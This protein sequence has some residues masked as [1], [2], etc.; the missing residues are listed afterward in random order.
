M[1]STTITTAPF[2]TPVAVASPAGTLAVG[3]PAGYTQADFIGAN[4]STDAT[5]VVNGNDLFQEA[6]DEFDISYGA[7]SATITNK[8]GVNW[9]AG[10]ELI[11]GF[12]FASSSQSGQSLIVD[13]LGVSGAATFGSTISVAGAATFSG[14]LAANLGITGTRTGAGIVVSF[15]GE[16]ATG[17]TA[18]RY[19]SSALA[20]ATTIMGHARGTIA[21]PS[22]LIQN[23]YARVD[24]A[25]AWLT[26]GL[27]TTGYTGIRQNAATPSSTD[28]GN[29]FV[30]AL[31]AQ[32]GTA[33]ADTF[34]V[35]SNRTTIGAGV[36]NIAV[37]KTPASAA[38]TGQAGD[39]CYDASYIY[40]CTATNA[41]ERVAIAT[42]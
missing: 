34:T 33:I 1:A 36:L 11:V 39:I 25:Q 35:N 24:Y 37:P 29:E 14:T 23:D 5:L 9:P 28:Y 19:G 7:S 6:D 22:S 27:K 3:Y 26:D 8:T 20:A 30:V 2:L 10:T 31:A 41:W 42:W 15:S 32:G 13:T 40:V 16:G 21:V 12:A 4:A 18:T 17:L 38:A